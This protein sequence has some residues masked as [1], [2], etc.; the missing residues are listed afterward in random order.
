MHGC[1]LPGVG[2]VRMDDFPM[3]VTDVLA[4]VVSQGSLNSVAPKSKL[5]QERLLTTPFLSIGSGFLPHALEIV[6]HLFHIGC[7]GTHWTTSC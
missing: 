1:S 3:T 5:Q 4:W 7:E 2:M 6:V